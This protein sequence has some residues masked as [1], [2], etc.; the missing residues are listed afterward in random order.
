MSDIKIKD[1]NQLFRSEEYTSQF[2]EKKAN[3]ENACPSTATAE[4]AEYTKTNEY[5]DKN[6]ARTSLTVNPAKACQP[7]GAILAAVG[8]EETLPFVHGSQG[9]VAYFR[10]HFNRH[11]KEP[12]SAVSS[13]MTED[14]AVFGGL[15]NMI[16]GL[17]NAKTVYKP[18]MIAVSTTCMAEVIGD[19][20]NSFIKNTKNKGA[21]PEDFPVPYAHTPSFVGSHITGY[22]NM[23]VGILQ[24]LTEGKKDTPNKKINI[25]PGF[26][27]YV[28][29][30]RE[31]KHMLSSMGVE[32]TVLADNADVLDSPNNGEYHMYVGGTKLADAADSINSAATIA[33]QKYSTSKTLAYIAKDWEKP[34][35]AILPWGIAGTDKFL[36]EVSKI[37]G[38]AISKEL[39]DER[40][41]LLDAMTD[42]HA[43][44]H[45]KKFA[46]YGDPD[47]TLG[48]VAFLLEMGGE[49]VHVLATNG[50][51]H[52]E[53]EM[54]ELLASS[55]F[56]AGAKVYAGKD[57]WH[58]RSLLFTEPVDF[59][60]GNTY[61][62]FLMRDTGTPLIRVGFPIFDR[63]H[64]H[65]YS[66]IGYQGGLNL[67][68]WMV[69]TI[70]DEMDR[71]T[72]DT[73]KTDY[74]FDI[75]R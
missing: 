70:L 33:L 68:T 29:N 7:L 53:A 4:Q 62:K 54:T 36:S 27:T 75:I 51:K 19:D 55:P 22:D 15:N 39:E 40:G 37:T 2:A 50:D 65:R 43:Y 30:I 35:S 20:L 8:F 57:L 24:N 74:S 1:H 58:L 10:S 66:T 12:F 11:F 17:E 25:I 14:A 32:Y 63:H 52:W 21:I 46:V 28:G 69:N 61:G 71:N 5:Q 59:L 67:L 18:K 38:K 13:S 42:S 45:G 56:G 9:C 34:A 41:R 3:W 23:L 48:V 60:I 6:F 49:P 16:E 31:V 47:V 72:I 44:I 73:A 26:E 64:L